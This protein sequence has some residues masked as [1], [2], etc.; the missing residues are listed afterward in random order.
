[1][2]KKP[3]KYGII[4]MQINAIILTL[5]I[6]FVEMV[7][8]SEIQNE[9]KGAIKWFRHS[10]KNEAKVVFVCSESKCISLLRQNQG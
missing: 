9:I 7:Y 10:Q 6:R 4:F 1:M 8:F 5:L 3:E 2:K